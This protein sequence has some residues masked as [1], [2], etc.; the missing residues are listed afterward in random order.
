MSNYDGNY[1]QNGA[2]IG[3]DWVGFL[4]LAGTS[5]YLTFKLMQ[6]KGPERD[7]QY[8]MGYR[9]DKM[10][11]VFVNLFAAMAYWAR[12][13]SHANGDV[14]PAANI[15]AYKYLDYVLTCPLL[16]IDLLWSLNLP[17][18]FTYGGFVLC[19]IICAFMCSTLDGTARYMWFGLGI[20]LFGYTWYS[21]IRV[22]KLRLDQF[23]SEE[24]K[25]VRQSLK[26]ACMTYFGIWCGYP[27]LWLLLE[28]GVITDVISAI[29][30]TVFDVLAK[31]VYG[32]ALL[33]FVLKG[34]KSTLIFV[35]LTTNAKPESSD[36]GSE[37]GSSTGSYEERTT[38][39]RSK[40]QGTVI[41]ASKPNSPHRS[42][43]RDVELPSTQGWNNFMPTNNGGSP[44]AGMHPMQQQPNGGIPGGGNSAWM[45]KH[46]EQML[47]QQQNGNSGMM[48][49]AN[50]N[51][52]YNTNQGGPG[53]QQY[54]AM[55][56]QAGLGGSDAAG[57]EGQYQPAAAHDDVKMTMH[58]IQAIDEQL[59]VLTS[60]F[61]N[62][63]GGRKAV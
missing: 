51:G 53:D 39:R 33:H 21:I 18:K 44:M 24:A 5:V 56:L 50:G 59:S 6:F 9:E 14:G 37:A 25:K 23:V 20:M 54:Q 34:E 27:T 60:Q 4:S 17:Y 29:L 38:S 3:A 13:C 52:I 49:G 11:S 10:L 45:F 47:A 1:L 32:F 42:H 58:Q 36:G 57:A 26:I 46:L 61:A 30:H 43:M 40:K 2:V 48:N 41:G 63:N 62:S 16:T 15:V 35:P 22:V 31:S 55:Q 28:A 19:C 7:D 8:Y 12:L